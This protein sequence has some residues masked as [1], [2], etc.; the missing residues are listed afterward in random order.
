M[1]LFLVGL[2]VTRTYLQTS[3]VMF[4]VSSC[5]CVC[6]IHWNQVLSREWRCSWS[7]GGRRCSNWVINNFIACKDAAYIKYL[8][9]FFEWRILIFTLVGSYKHPKM[10]ITCSGDWLWDCL[11]SYF[12]LWL[13]H[14]RLI[15]SY[16]YNWYFFSHLTI[17]SYT[18]LYNFMADLTVSK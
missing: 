14:L 10:K 18:R 7:I 12:S 17:L 11:G 13:H 5:S 2:F 15:H 4:L 16:I 3:N 9:V 8:Q 6:P 1:F